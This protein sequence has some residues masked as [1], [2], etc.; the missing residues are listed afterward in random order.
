MITTQ[1]EKLKQSVTPYICHPD[2]PR[3]KRR[4][5]NR[6]R[7]IRWHF[8]VDLMHKFKLQSYGVKRAYENSELWQVHNAVANYKRSKCMA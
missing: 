1:N 8:S 3:R 2:G 6:K 5:W 4:I 7:C